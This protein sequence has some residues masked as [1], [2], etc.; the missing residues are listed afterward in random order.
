M[1]GRILSTVLPSQ[2]PECLLLLW[3]LAGRRAVRVC[4][5]LQCSDLSWVDWRGSREVIALVFSKALDLSL[6]PFNTPLFQTPAIALAFIRKLSNTEQMI[7]NLDINKIFF[8]FSLTD[9]TRT[10]IPSSR[11]LWSSAPLNLSNLG[12]GSRSYRASRIIMTKANRVRGLRAVNGCSGFFGHHGPSSRN[13]QPKLYKTRNTTMHKKTRFRMRQGELHNESR[14][15]RKEG[16][17]EAKYR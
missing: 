14:A 1:S 9:T 2:F 3:K 8:L 15:A 16:S 7:H 13:T 4:L 12:K 11:G 5:S 17:S 6:R 10:K